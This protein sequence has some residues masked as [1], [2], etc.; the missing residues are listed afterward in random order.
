MKSDEV[1]YYLKDNPQFFEE[2]SELMANMVIPHPHVGRT[3]SVTELQMLAM[4]G[5]NTQLE[6]K[7]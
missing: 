6:R 2:H 3:I 7:K 4:R 1:A 5:K